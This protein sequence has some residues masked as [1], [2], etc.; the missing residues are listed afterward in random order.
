VLLVVGAVLLLVA[1]RSIPSEVVLYR[2]PWAD[3]PRV[4]PKSFLSVGRIVLM[5][6]GQVGAATAMVVVSRGSVG[7]E[8]CW[9]WLGVVAAGKT[10]FECLGLLMPRGSLIEQ[11]LTL[12]TL[13]AVGLFALMVGWW[14]Q[15]GDLRSHPPL[16]RR[17]RVWLLAS[18]VVWALFA[19]APQW[20]LACER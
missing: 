1:Y 17:P 9:R 15:R 7:W 16:T 5:G 12:S 20:S 18:L 11:T 10:L 19:L 6:V 2:A 3:A 8:R 13:G 4:G 14:W